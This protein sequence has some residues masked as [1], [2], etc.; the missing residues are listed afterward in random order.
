[1]SRARQQLN[2]PR[3]YEGL[4]FQFAAIEREIKSFDRICRRFLDDR[5]QEVLDRWLGRL[6]S[7]RDSRHRGYW[8]WEIT[9][10]D[11]VRTRTDA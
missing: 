2:L 4:I 3:P 1:M 7:F 9:E 5:S 8:R 11:P 10:S 6:L